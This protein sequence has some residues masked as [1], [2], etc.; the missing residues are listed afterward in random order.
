[1]TS[2]PDA[3]I[4]SPTARRCEWL[5]AGLTLLGLAVSVGMGLA[6]DGY[7]MDDDLTHYLFAAD[8]SSNVNALLHRWARPGFN[9]P[10]A[11][12]A[13]IGGLPACRVLSALMTAGAAYLSWRIARRLLGAGLWSAFVP[14]M[15]WLQPMVFKLSLTTLTETP[16]L[17]YLTA[18]VWLYLRGNCIAG[19]A[20]VSLL[21]VTR[22]ET[23][24][25][26][27]LMGLAVLVDARRQRV[28]RTDDKPAPA[29][30]GASAP[31][32]P[33]AVR[34]ARN[35]PRAMAAIQGILSTWW[36]WASAAALAWAVAAYWLAAWWFDLP[37]DASPL[38]IFGKQY[39]D[40]YGRGSWL[41]YLGIWPDAAGLGVLM[42]AVGGAVWIG[43]RGWLV[44][45]WVF[46][47][48]ALHTLIFARGMFASG[49]YS[50]FVVPAGGLLAVL[51]GGGLKAVF[52][53]KRTRSAVTILVAGAV[54]LPLTSYVVW[55]QYDVDYSGYFLW[56]A[57]GLAAA[58]VAVACLRRSLLT[59]TTVGALVVVAQ[60]PRL[61]VE[62][63]PLRLSDSAMHE[64]LLL[65]RDRAAVMGYGENLGYAQHV[66]LQH[67]RPHTLSPGGNDQSVTLWR[68]AQ[69]GTLYFWENKYAHK[70]HDMEST[71]RLQDAL[72]RFGKCI[73][74]VR[75]ES[76]N[77]FERGP[78]VKVYVRSAEPAGGPQP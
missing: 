51:A 21:F 75:D 59:W 17:L 77:D 76:D 54:W 52:A 69:P 68:Q 28:A 61:A 44:S 66:L 13:R 27:P 50:R 25:M 45:A 11:L 19:C 70:P 72:E 78:H 34:Q 60:V 15:I 49:G 62:V 18:G 16:G 12:A 57:A 26:A 20:V 14:L 42:L 56:P 4:A 71:Q 46:G 6:S 3:A 43:R 38:H 73:I 23:M 53:E 7:F 47:L 48:V 63:H 41:H 64:T 58:A 37:P 8:G 9:I 1:M 67:H 31:P 10:M 35:R 65:V 33:K 2:A 22:D 30:G 5:A 29:C 55:R 32:R 40:E 36:V 24:A 39:T 74:D